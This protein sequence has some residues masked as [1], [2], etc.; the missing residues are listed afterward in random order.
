[1]QVWRVCS[2]KYQRFDG[3]GARLYGGR[4]N[5]PGIAVVY[6]SASLALAAL[7]LFVHV[8]ADLMPSDLVAVKADIPENLEPVTVKAESLPKKWRRYPAP[9]AL[10]T[11]G[12]AWAARGSSVILAVP[13]AIIPEENNYL[14]NPAHRDFKRIHLNK[15][16]PFHLDPRMWK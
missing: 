15:P 13:S 7:E 9:D 10:K 5:T 11:I 6:A 8:D 12:T 4:W 2:K 16:I 14:L 1:M 3:V